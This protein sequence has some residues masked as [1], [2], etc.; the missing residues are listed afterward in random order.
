MAIWDLTSSTCVGACTGVTSYLIIS[1][2][3]GP[4]CTQDKADFSL[5]TNISTVWD[6]SLNLVSNCE[7]DLK[8]SDYSCV[9]GQCSTVVIELGLRLCTESTVNISWTKIAGVAGKLT[10]TMAKTF[11]VAKSR[12]TD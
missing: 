3:Y 10:V 4:I 6:A 2:N 1:K 7:G 9:V 12:W 11:N 8:L 5:D